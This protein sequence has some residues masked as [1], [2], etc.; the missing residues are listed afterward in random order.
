MKDARYWHPVDIQ[1]I[2]HRIQPCDILLTQSLD[3]PIGKVIGRL[4]GRPRIGDELPE[5]SHGAFCLGNE[6]GKVIESTFP[7]GGIAPLSKY[8]GR[9]R[10]TWIFS[11]PWSSRSR[12]LTLLQMMPLAH[13]P[14]DTTGLLL[15]AADNIIERLTWN[16]WKQRGKRPLGRLVGDLDGAERN[17]C[18]EAM[19]RAV[20][21]AFGEPIDPSIP[22]GFERPLDW[23][24]WCRLHADFVGMS[25]RGM[26]SDNLVAEPSPIEPEIPA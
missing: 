15:H 1:E 4:Q 6:T 8:L 26:W 9:N 22:P 10:T 12:A 19:G 24:F 25:H 17:V 2:N 21:K 16:P 20:Y 7:R 14:Y 5:L 18:T 3:T 23:W 13:T 11:P